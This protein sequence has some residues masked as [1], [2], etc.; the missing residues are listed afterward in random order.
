MISHKHKC[1]FIHIPKTGGMSMEQMLGVDV[2]KFHQHSRSLVKHGTP[3]NEYYK[4]YFNQDLGYFKFTIVRNPWDRAVSIFYHEKKM[5][6]TNPNKRRR[7]IVDF[8]KKYKNKAFSEFIKSKLINKSHT[9]KDTLWKSQAQFLTDKYDFICKFEDLE[10]DVRHVCNKLNIDFSNF[11][12]INKGAK[13]TKNYKEL[14]DQE[15]IDIITDLYK[16][17]FKSLNYDN[18]WT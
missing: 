15:S 8:C 14:Y 12:H 1:V 5:N 6:Q 7:L 13:P 11:P 10:A 2:L 16:Q 17:Y 9:L 18:T 4:K 3:F